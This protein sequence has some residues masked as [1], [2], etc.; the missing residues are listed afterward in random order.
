GK[1]TGK[2]WYEPALNF[3][4]E[5]MVQQD[6]TIAGTRPAPPAQGKPNAAKATN[7]PLEKFSTPV[8]QQ[9]TTRLTQFLSLEEPS[10][11]K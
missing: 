4:V 11:A 6:F 1:S 9:M 2:A 10:P 5:S 8:F 7:A 3:P